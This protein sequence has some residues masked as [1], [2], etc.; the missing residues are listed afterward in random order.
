MKTLLAL[1]FATVA[2]IQPLQ[3]DTTTQLNNKVIRG[4]S[5]VQ[6]PDGGKIWLCGLMADGTIDARLDAIAKDATLA[7]IAN[8]ADPRD[9]YLDHRY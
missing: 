5:F 6:F 7:A 1:T 4:D 3:F 8:G 9:V 2:T